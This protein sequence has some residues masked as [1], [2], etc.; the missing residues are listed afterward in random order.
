MSEAT[1]KIDGQLRSDFDVAKLAAAFGLASALV[2][3][4]GAVTSWAFARG[5]VGSIGF[6]AQIV[7]LRSSLDCFSSMAFNY[8]AASLFMLALGFVL[9]SYDA[10]KAA[11]RLIVCIS[12]GGMSVLVDIVGELWEP[13]SDFYRVAL[14]LAAQGSPLLVGYAYRSLSGSQRRRLTIAGAMCFVAFSTY[15]TFL[16]QLGR[17]TGVSISTRISPQFP[18]AEKGLSAVKSSDFPLIVLRTKEKLLVVSEGSKD[19]DQ[20]TYQPLGAEGFFRLIIQDEGNYYVVENH[21]GA[22]TPIAIRKE[23]VS[24]IIFYSASSVSAGVRP[25][26]SESLPR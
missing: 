16:Y 6:P 19:G 21:K 8:V 24:Q 5:L 12:A 4:L 3:F 15:T 26:S 7:T 22:I 9:T 11:R 20:F 18:I 13:H 2:L 17:E 10:A 14:L 25:T 1:E 23:I